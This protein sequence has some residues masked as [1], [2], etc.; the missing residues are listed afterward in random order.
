MKILRSYNVQIWCGLKERDTG[1]IHT[2]EDVRA[3]CDKFVNE[4][5]DCVTISATEYRYVNG[6][7]K[8]VVIGYIQYPRFPRSRKEIRK[9]AL[10]LGETLMYAFNQ[11]KVTVTTPYKSYML[12]NTEIEQ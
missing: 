8:G 1:E 9:R 10:K 12:E 11:Y 2:I 6:H 4:I 7:E 3:V 5:K